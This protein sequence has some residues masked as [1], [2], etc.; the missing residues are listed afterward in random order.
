MADL[1]LLRS[2]L[3]AHSAIFVMTSSVRV[4]LWPSLLSVR[5]QA[6]SQVTQPWLSKLR[7]PMILI[8]TYPRY[9]A[10]VSRNNVNGMYFGNECAITFPNFFSR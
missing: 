6:H 1:N 4:F 7:C 9:E 5:T 3:G 10:E 8:V 2:Q